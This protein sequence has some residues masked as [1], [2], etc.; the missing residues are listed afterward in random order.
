MR[1]EQVSWLNR[2]HARTRQPAAGIG[3][4]PRRRRNVAEQSLEFAMALSWF[5]L[6]RG[7]FR[8]GQECLERALSAAADAPAALRAR[9]LMSLGSLTFFQGDFDR[10]RVLLE[11]SASARPGRGDLVRRRVLARH[12]GA[13]GAGASA[14]CAEC[15]R[16]AAEGQ[17]AARASSDADG[18]GSRRSR[19]WRTRPC[20][21]ATSTAPAGCMRKCWRCAAGR[22]TSGA[23]ASC[24]STS[25][26]FASFKAATTKARALCA[27]GIVLDQEFGDRRGIAWCLGI[28][29]GAEAA[30]G[31]ALRAARL[32]GAM[33]G[34]LDSVGAPVQESFNR[35]IGDR[36]LDAM[37]ALAWRRARS[38][39]RWPKGAPC[40]SRSRS[41]SAWRTQDDL[42]PETCSCLWLRW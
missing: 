22:A 33:E 19:V 20:T 9:A 39:R 13:C 15:A 12:H 32:R 10:T 21:R 28:L 26:C 2:L 23:W 29:S 40:R 41:S 16:L 42:E 8:E 36:S 6:K 18:S 11:E 34:L 7:Y 37:K 38:T 31:R 4:V 3:V 35:L 14:T 30:D 1:A 17:A 25:R 24:C 27:E 5:W